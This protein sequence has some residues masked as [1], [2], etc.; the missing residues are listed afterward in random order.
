[1]NKNQRKQLLKETGLE[2]QPNDKLKTFLVC[3]LSPLSC[4]AVWLWLLFL[5]TEN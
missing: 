1:M 3:L 4:L 2:P 5:T